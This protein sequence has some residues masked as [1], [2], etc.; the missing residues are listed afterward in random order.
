MSARI[1]E[2]RGVTMARA[3]ET[4]RFGRARIARLAWAACGAA[5][6]AGALTLRASAAAGDPSHPLCLLRTV[7]GLACPTC[8]LTRAA[9]L[10]LAGEWRASLAMHPMAA[11][12]AVQLAAGWMAW[13]V[14]LARRS[15]ERIDRWIP[16]AIAVEAAAFLAIWILRLATGTLPR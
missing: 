16:H 5:A 8:G 7:T 1:A 3:V 14:A 11:A 9:A 13:G 2:A 12:L 4:A 15:R 6:M 10:L